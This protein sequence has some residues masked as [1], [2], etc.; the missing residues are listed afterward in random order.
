MINADLFSS[1]ACLRR[2]RVYTKSERREK[3]V[4]VYLFSA[5]VGAAAVADYLRA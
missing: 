3:S 1:F 2:K 4:G 5:N